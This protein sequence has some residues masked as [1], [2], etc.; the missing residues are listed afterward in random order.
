[1]PLPRS[2]AAS[3]GDT[4]PQPGAGSELDGVRAW[5]RGDSLRQ[6]LWK[7]VARSGELVSRE[8]SGSAQRQL[9]L[10]WQAGAGGDVEQRLSRL[11][12][13][14]LLAEREGLACGLRLPGRELAPGQG[15]AH[16]RSAL[17]LLALW[18]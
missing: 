18:P 8:T 16:R 3:A 17:D 11:A 13:W 9:W 1:P 6:V 14:V 10:D 12:A 5:R 2:H 7:K 4:A 15:E